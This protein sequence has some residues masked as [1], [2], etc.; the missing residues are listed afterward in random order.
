MRD[1]PD[2]PEPEQDSLIR[3]L[4]RAQDLSL[5]D[6]PPEN[7]GDAKKIFQDWFR[8]QSMHQDDEP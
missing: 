7:T 3:R 4:V 8:Q 6:R 2:D 1:A 5:I